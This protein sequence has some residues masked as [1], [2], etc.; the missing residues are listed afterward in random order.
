MR[1]EATETQASQDREFGQMEDAI[2]ISDKDDDFVAIFF[3]EAQ[4]P[5][6]R[7]LT[8][9][10]SR[11]QTGTGLGLS[12]R[13]G[14]SFGLPQAEGGT[15]SHDQQGKIAMHDDSRF[16]SLGELAQVPGMLALLEDAI[17]NHRAPIIGIKD[18][19]G[20][21]H[22]PIRQVDGAIG[23]GQPIV[24]TVYHDCIDGLP[25]IIAP[26]RKLRLLR[27]TIVIIGR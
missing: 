13:G 2:G 18:H 24:P 25:L 16:R 10:Q 17:L 26:M 27:I 7:A 14:G 12:V 4:T 1:R 20:I 9:E 19:K 23:G 5:T 15:Q 6:R 8:T 11:T 3:L 22:R 21:G